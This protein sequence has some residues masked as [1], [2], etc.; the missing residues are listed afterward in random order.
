MQNGNRCELDCCCVFRVIDEKGKSCE[1]WQMLNKFERGGISISFEGGMVR[2]DKG[3][4]L[5]RG[6]FS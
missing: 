5:L 2:Q 6:V 1:G 3:R 4:Q